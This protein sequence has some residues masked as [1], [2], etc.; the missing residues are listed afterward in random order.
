[1]KLR[2]DVLET[3]SANASVSEWLG[4]KSGC[5]SLQQIPLCST[6]RRKE[7][8]N[9]VPDVLQLCCQEDPLALFRSFKKN[10]KQLSLVR[11]E[12]TKKSSESECKKGSV[13]PGSGRF[14]IY[15]G[16][17]GLDV[18]LAI[19]IF[20]KRYLRMYNIHSQLMTV[21]ICQARLMGEKRGLSALAAKLP[22]ACV[23]HPTARGRA[24]GMSV[25]DWRRLVVV[26]KQRASSPVPVSHFHAYSHPLSSSQA[27][28][29]SAS[30]RAKRGVRVGSICLCDGRWC[31][32]PRVPEGEE[33][34]LGWSRRR[35]DVSGLSSG[36]PG[37]TENEGDGCAKIRRL[38]QPKQ[39]VLSRSFFR[40]QSQQ[41]AAASR[42][43]H[44]NREGTMAKSV[45]LSSHSQ[46]SGGRGG[47]WTSL[48]PRIS[49]I[50]VRNR[51]ALRFQPRRRQ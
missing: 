47:T 29:L 33:R 23:L 36:V 7:P 11:L 13:F 17:G 46:E 15:T 51:G 42:E 20:I 9:R 32:A 10:P 45:S 19:V 39:I 43:R 37:R 16:G 38:L 14:R 1:M 48:S 27:L 2:G 30:P 8:L 34:R 28:I 18:P 6:G 4:N 44:G 25:G 3:G 21:K 49:F 50:P 24:K 31:Q 41:A 22:A 35:T 40:L 5:C 26:T 12:K